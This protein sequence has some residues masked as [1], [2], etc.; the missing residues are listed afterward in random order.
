[1]KKAL[2]PLVLL[3]ALLLTSCTNAQPEVTTTVQPEE[4]T[5]EAETTTE[6]PTTTAAA[7]SV[8]FRGERIKAPGEYANVPKAYFP[9][10]DDAYLYEELWCH[11][12]LL[13]AEAQEKPNVRAEYDVQTAG[14]RQ[15]GYVKDSHGGVEHTG[16]ALV[17]LDGDKT[18]ELLLDNTP[19]A[20]AEAQH[21]KICAVF[22]IRGGKAVSIAMN[23]AGEPSH[24]PVLAADG[25]FYSRE[26]WSGSARIRMSAQRLTAKASALTSVFEA[27]SDVVFSN[28]DIPVFDWVKS[29]NGK[30]SKISETEFYRLLGEYRKPRAQMKLNF[31]PLHPGKK[32]PPQNTAPATPVEYPKSYP[33][34]P[35]EYK[36]LL[37]DLYLFSERLRRNESLDGAWGK[38]E[39]VEIP[40]NNDG[41]NAVE[42][43]AY[44][45]VDINND[46]IQEL[47]LG[48]IDGLTQAAPNSLF[49]L[50]NGKPVHLG[51]YWGRSDCV[52]AQD[53][54]IYVSGSGGAHNTYFSS[55]RLNKRADS[56]TTLDDIFSDYSEAERKAYFVQTIDGRLRFVSKKVFDDFWDFYID[57]PSRMKARVY[58]IASQNQ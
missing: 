23:G 15:R 18:P 5:A 12:Q 1:M 45:L 48:S 30:E 22:A 33:G 26:D 2:L 24:N 40:Y 29:E 47:W 52:V 10:L 14:I 8:T 35:K 20:S 34:A 53:G 57:P 11:W 21:P 46:G 51:T 3:L 4:T 17:H 41:R 25:L 19:P 49:T 43:L 55:Y 44:A 6:A 32:N 50:K 36:A 9:V 31:V 27:R 13:S 39:F 54:M 28:G 56:L 7:G 58:P 37:D 16:Y 38:L 42:A